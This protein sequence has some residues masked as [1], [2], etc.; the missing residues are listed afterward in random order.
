ME[1]PQWKSEDGY[2]LQ[3]ATNHLG[4]FL[5]TNLLL[6]RIKK[7]APSRIINVSSRRHICK[8]INKKMITTLIKCG[9]LLQFACFSLIISYLPYRFLDGKIHFDDIN[10][11]KDYTPRKAYDQS[12]LANVLFTRELHKRLEGKAIE[13]CITHHELYFCTPRIAVLDI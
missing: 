10:L 13:S 6:D 2:E 9:G 12:K 7:S 11:K 8:C 3:F 1:C 5:L 4:H